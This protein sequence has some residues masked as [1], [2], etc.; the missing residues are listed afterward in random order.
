MV[1]DMTQGCKVLDARG[2]TLAQV[3][4]E[5]GEAFTLAQVTLAE[6]RPQPQGPQPP[7]PLSPLVYL[8]SDLVLPWLSVP[9][10]RRG[11][12]RAWGQDMAPVRIS[13]RQWAALLG[14]SAVVGW[15]IGMF[16]RQKP[17]DHTP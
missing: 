12:R 17:K 4:Q 8:L 3:T 13:A 6:R 14:G 1:C 9:T 15:L 16:F 10:Y 5:Q 11:L 7:A 2:Q